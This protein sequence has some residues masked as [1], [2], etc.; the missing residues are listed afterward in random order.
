MSAVCTDTLDRPIGG[1][2]LT[3]KSSDD[4]YDRGVTTS[5]APG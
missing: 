5:S 3:F 1:A 2:R 4:R